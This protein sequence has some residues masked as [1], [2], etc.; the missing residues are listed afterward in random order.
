MEAL[1]ARVET[2]PGTRATSVRS[3]PF[4]TTCRRCGEKLLRRRDPEPRLAVL[5]AD[6]HMRRRKVHGLL[7]AVFGLDVSLGTLS[8]S[9]QIVSEAA[10]S[11]LDYLRRRNAF[12]KLYLVCDVR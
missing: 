10:L 3:C 11:C 5:T 4:P 8:E 12:G 2:G 6:G 9:K 7:A 1:L